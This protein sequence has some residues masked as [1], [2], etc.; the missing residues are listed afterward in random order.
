M[1][2][3]KYKNDEERISARKETACESLARVPQRQFIQEIYL[4]GCYRNFELR[5]TWT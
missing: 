5:Y 1:E 3:E 2:L 4:L